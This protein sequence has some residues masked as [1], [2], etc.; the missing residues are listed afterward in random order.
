MFDYTSEASKLR[1]K[2]EKISDH[3]SLIDVIN[4]N[5]D[6][7]NKWKVSI[8]QDM[9]EIIPNIPELMGYSDLKSE[10]VK[11]NSE[12]FLSLIHSSENNYYSY[13]FK[14]EEVLLF[15]PPILINSNNKIFCYHYENNYIDKINI[16]N[17]KLFSFDRDFII[18]NDSSAR[19]QSLTRVIKPSPFTTISLTINLNLNFNIFIYHYENCFIKEVERIKLDKDLSITFENKYF[20]AYINNSI[21]SILDKNGIEVYS[22]KSIFSDIDVLFKAIFPYISKSKI[23][24]VIQQI[25]KSE[26]FHDFIQSAFQ[27]LKFEELEEVL[28]LIYPIYSLPKTVKT[29]KYIEENLGLKFKKWN[30]FNGFLVVLQNVIQDFIDKI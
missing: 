28:E 20:I 7:V 13:G 12:D 4:K 10:S 22:E 1:D 25:E 16:D 17:L 5:R 9:S 23:E 2:F 11:I 29:I 26:D 14:D 24:N 18:K 8:N 27:D 6:K 3:H 21:S 19:L 30:N 15:I